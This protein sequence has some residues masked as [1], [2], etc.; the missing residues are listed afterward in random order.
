ML[1]IEFLEQSNMN[2]YRQAMRFAVRMVISIVIMVLLGMMLDQLLGCSPLF[3]ILLVSY[4]TIGNLY[5]L[6]K[7]CREHE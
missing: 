2:G 5:L 7:E 1:A 6:V 4:A 3:L